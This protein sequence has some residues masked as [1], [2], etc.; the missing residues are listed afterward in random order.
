MKPLAAS[1][2]KGFPENDVFTFIELF[3][4]LGV[5]A[6]VYW[7]LTQYALVPCALVLDVQNDFLQDLGLLAQNRKQNLN[8]GPAYS[9]AGTS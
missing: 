5:A 3:R 7:S 2:I 8:M 9:M 6:R 4:E 1:T